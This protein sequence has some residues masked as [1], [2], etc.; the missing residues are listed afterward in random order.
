MTYGGKRAL[1]P[2]YLSNDFGPVGLWNFNGHMRDSSPSQINLSVNAG[3]ERYMEVSPGMRGFRFDGATNLQQAA[4]GTVLQISGD[5]TVQSIIIPY[6]PSQGYICAYIGSGSGSSTF[7]VLYSLICN[8]GPPWVE[9]FWQTGTNSNQVWPSAASASK[10]AGFVFG[11][12]MHYAMVRSGSTAFLY[13]NGVLAGPPST[14][15][16][17]PTDG[18]LS[19]LRVG[20]LTSGAVFFNGG[21]TSLKINKT[22]LTADQIKYEYN[23]SLGN[24][25][26]FVP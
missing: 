15:L 4:F 13:T 21:L 1:G 12:P 6:V 20:S 7:N 17:A 22:A 5:V 23:K 16:T 24:I 8:G 14:G 11:Q 9:T 18:S 25:L 2:V 10:N 19:I 26:G 3:N